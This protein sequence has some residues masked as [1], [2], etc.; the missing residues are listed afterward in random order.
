MAR[1]TLRYDQDSMVQLIQDD[2]SEPSRCLPWQL[3]QLNQSFAAI[4]SDLH[5]QYLSSMEA[6]SCLHSIFSCL[7][8]EG[9]LRVTV[10]DLDYWCRQWLDA[11]WDESSLRDQGSPAQQAYTHIFGPQ[12]H[13]NPMLDDYQPQHRARY[14]SG[15]NRRRLRFLLER[16]GFVDVNIELVAGLLIATAR[17][18]M[19]PGERQ[20]AT[21]RANIRVDHLVR[22]QFAAEQLQL[23]RPHSIL[24]LACGIGYGSQ[25]LAEQLSGQVLGI[26]IDAGAIDYAQ[27]Y[28]HHPRLIFRCCDARVLE[29]EPASTDAIVCFETL[30]HIDFA[31]ELLANFYRWLKVGGYLIASTPNQDCLPFDPQRFPFH[32]QHY[33]VS[34]MRALL[35]QAGFSIQ[36]VMFQ[37]DQHSEQLTDEPGE[38][39]VMVAQK[40]Q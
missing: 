12:Q 9:Q 33:Q 35:E 36:K 40:I 4:S 2:G 11:Q 24:D 3:D 39:T 19:Q 15:Y 7:T 14:L 21:S 28:Y 17:K 16:V 8:I 27:R 6:D 32:R 30:E 13:N 5:L 20:I 10:P 1:L 34:Q 25:Y 37:P 29:R 38:F 31:A 26:D 23:V 22:Y 18:S